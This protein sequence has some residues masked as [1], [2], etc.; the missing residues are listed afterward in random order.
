MKGGVEKEE[1]RKGDV[2][3]EM[4]RFQINYKLRLPLLWNR[5]SNKHADLLV[6]KQKQRNWADLLLLGCES[7]GVMVPLL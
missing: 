4:S 5:G 7:F 1:K 3:N 6:A 2:L